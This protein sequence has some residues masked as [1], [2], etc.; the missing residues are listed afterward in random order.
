MRKNGFLLG[1][2]G[3][4]AIVGMTLTG[5]GDDS[6]GKKDS[7]VAQDLSVP[8]G[9]NCAGILSCSIQCGSQGATCIESCI[10]KGT[11]AAQST[12]GAITACGIA[13]CEVSTADGGSADGGGAA[14]ASATDTSAA[15]VAC[16]TAAAQSA[17]CAS[18][19]SACE[20]S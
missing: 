9:T 2:L 14:C 12:F 5:C 13:A 16:A 20:N 17:T 7:A 15:C 10:S 8:T 4:A 6:G 1:I 19:I 11:T 3:V 18:E